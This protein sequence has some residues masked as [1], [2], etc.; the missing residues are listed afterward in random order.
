MIKANDFRVGNFVNEYYYNSIVGKYESSLIKVNAVYK[1]HIVCQDD[2]AYGFSDISPIPLTEDILL[3]CGF[4]SHYSTFYLANS[5]FDI[6]YN[7]EL[8]N[9]I[10]ICVG[11]YCPRG[12]CF[13]HIKFLHQLQNL[14]F[15]LTG[16]ELEINL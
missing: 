7:D 12:R 15:A 10:S 6:S 9:G 3:K 5:D 4:E 2:C 14:Y 16:T 11:D 1:T 8:E 13:E